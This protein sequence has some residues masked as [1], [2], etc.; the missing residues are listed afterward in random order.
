MSPPYIPPGCRSFEIDRRFQGVGRI[1]MSS[2]TRSKRVFRKLD[3]LLTELYEDGRL[4][5]LRA[6][7]DGR[8]SLREVYDAKR[9]G[10]LTYEPTEL[11][12]R[13]PLWRE[14]GAWLEDAAPTEATRKRYEVSFRSLRATGVLEAGARVHDLARVDWPALRA[15]WDASG[16]DWNRMRAAVSRFLS[17]RLGDKWHPFRRRLMDAIPRARERKRHAPDLDVETFWRLVDATPEH[18]RAAYVAL[19]ATGMRIGEYLALEPHHLRPH[20]RTVEVPGTKTEE[21]ARVVELS[22]A[23]WEWLERAVPPP[24]GYKW[25]RVH[26]KR[27][28]EEVGLPDL[29]LHDLRHLHGHVLADAGLADSKIGTQLGHTS[30]QTTRRYTR[31]GE[32]GQAA[33]AVDRWLFRAPEDDPNSD[34]GIPCTSPSEE[35]D[36]A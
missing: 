32:T 26:F 31:H 10:V 2:G 20:T 30:A 12:L 24:L 25:T 5:V 21:S 17:V 3:S 1:R 11:V 27:A 36:V 7:R 6:I 33:E 28:A 35:S 4:E 15:G 8:V 14:V 29:R 13:R 16:A 23:A 34:R 22:P 18:V 9:R 19:M